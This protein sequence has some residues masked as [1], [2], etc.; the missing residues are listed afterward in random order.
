M[1]IYELSRQATLYFIPVA[2]WGKEYYI[3][4]PT[5]EAGVSVPEEKLEALLRACATIPDA[6]T[7]IQIWSK[8][9]NFTATFLEKSPAIL[10]G[11]EMEDWHKQ[12]TELM[13]R[14]KYKKEDVNLVF[15]SFLQSFGGDS[16][17]DNRQ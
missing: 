11:D 4:C 7:A 14:T 13:S 16:S 9:M 3:I 6:E 1:G 10:G 5:C 8:M 2:K 15:L 12:I 17:T